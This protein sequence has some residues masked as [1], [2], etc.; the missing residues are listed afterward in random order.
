M[1]AALRLRVL[2]KYPV[3]WLSIPR[4]C[5]GRSEQVHHKID[6]EDGGPDTE[7][8]LV[9]VCTACHTHYSAVR[10]G[11]RSHSYRRQREKHPG[12]LD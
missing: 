4:F 2:D 5:T 9:G 7:D 3:C 11:Q 8:N 1:P 10:S 12:V 6:A